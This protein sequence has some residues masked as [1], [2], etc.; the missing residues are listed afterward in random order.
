MLN[1]FFKHHFAKL[2]SFK[3][4]S[5]ARYQKRTSGDLWHRTESSNATK[6]L[7][8]VFGIDG[9]SS[10]QTGRHGL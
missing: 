6:R 5:L 4:E 2:T 1:S 7:G 10:Q 3:G 8:Q 9:D